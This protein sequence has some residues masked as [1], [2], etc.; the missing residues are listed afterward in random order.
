MPPSRPPARARLTAPAIAALMLTVCLLPAVGGHRPVNPNELVRIEHALSMAL[1]AS[2]DLGPLAEIY[3]VSEDIAVRDGR[4]LSDKAPGLAMTAVPIVW[5]AAPLLPTAAGTDFPAYWFLRHLLVAVL[6]AMPAVLAA[7]LVGHA[8]A[9]GG[10][11][12]GGETLAR[13]GVALGLATPLLTYGTVLF[14]HAL[15][16]GC[17]A[18]SWLPL[19]ARWRR[20]VGID[21]RMAFWTGLAAGFAV[22][23]EYP[24]VI[25]SATLVVTVASDRDASRRVRAVFAGAAAFGLLPTLLVHHFAFGAPWRTGYAFKAAPDFSSIHGEGLVGVTWPSLERLWGVLASTERGLFWFCPVLVLALAGSISGARERQRG[26]LALTAAITLYIVFAAGFVDWRAGWCAAARHLTPAIPLLMLLTVDGLK[27]LTRSV[28]GTALSVA[29]ATVSTI[30]AIL[31][32][33]VT[34]FFPVEFDAPLTQLVIPT[35]AEGLAAPTVLGAVTGAPDVAVWLLAGLVTLAVVTACLAGLSGRRRLTVGVAALTVVVHGLLLT[36]AATAR[37]PELEP[38]R[39]SLVH[40][41]GL[42]P[43]DAG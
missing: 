39:V 18:A 41:L 20:G 17:V 24:T 29:L 30:H 2:H 27:A 42:G 43:E 16:A 26:T 37:P 10:S 34:P 14:G 15:A 38:Y 12:R 6:A 19:L 1:W 36:A 11:G 31:S 9:W 40:F 7:W 21:G 25:L 4:V 35:L 28:A 32:V 23:T 22:G 3:G 8:A 13:L 33:A 5:L